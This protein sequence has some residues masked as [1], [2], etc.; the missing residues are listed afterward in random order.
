[1]TAF[2][3]SF[4]HDPWMLAGLAAL[5]VPPLIHLLNRRRYAVVDWGAMQFLQL[6]QAS[7]RRV[8]L[9][10]LLLMLLRMGLIA[11]LVFALAGPF[12]TSTTLA[13]MAPEG[14][15]DLA[16]VFDG[17]F[18]MGSL[19]RNGATPHDAAREWALALLDDLAP[20]DAVAVFQARETVLPVVAE[21]SR[22]LRRVREEIAKLP[23]PSGGCDW[24]PAVKA[25]HDALAAG[26][27]P[28]RDIVLLTDGQKYGWADPEG[29][30]R[31]RLLAGELAA[32]R[33]RDNGPPPRLWVV[34]V[35][36]DRKGDLP[37]WALAP[38]RS[39]RP[40]VP[41][42]REVSF[43]TALDVRHQR[44]GYAPPHRIR[45]EV[46]G[47]P[48]RDLAPP[49]SAQ[50]Q[51]GGGVV[52]FAF[53]HRFSTPG[54]HLVSVLLEPDPP[55]EQ[56]PPGYEPRD[57]LPGD[58]RQ[59]F[60]F[61]VVRSLPVLLVDG[62]GST[63]YLRAALAP[64]GETNPAVE[65]RVVGWRDFD[66]ALLEPSSGTGPSRPRVVV[67]SDVPSLNDA[68]QEA[69]TQFLADGGGVLIAPG[70]RANAASYNGPLHRDGKGWLPARLERTEGS[71]HIP[72][73][74]ARPATGM[75]DHP[76]LQLL[77]EKDSSE[78]GP[79]RFPQLA[80]ARFPAGGSWACRPARRR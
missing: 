9:E 71:E 54:S 42:G 8:F 35:A 26:D 77:L 72:A 76:A 32:A 19:D 62:G 21:P 24:R 41:V 1:M 74:A 65:V 30:F 34:N 23:P 14:N 52:P 60:A 43:Q 2:L 57:Q 25:A 73:N 40:V 66:P 5:A 37:N 12:V 16:L 56:R 44:G 39:S 18:S 69:L 38:L 10:E 31:W 6:G 48:V 80:E 29:L 27:R 17:S 15:R 45:L 47:R 61:E 53:S 28:R 78:V 3:G 20:G 7:R 63:D 68:Q 22:D 51:D 55:P 13:R 36:P 49:A 33:S 79:P 75:S 64:A 59:D 58:N 67:L 50:L 11:L 70:G 4:L 46:D